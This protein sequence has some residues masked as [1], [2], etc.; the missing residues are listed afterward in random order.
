MVEIP[1]AEGSPS[2]DLQVESVGDEVLI[3]DPELDAVK[4]EDS[5]FD[6]NLAE[7]MSDKEL[8]RTASDL[9]GFS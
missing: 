8:S 9:I 3:G 5:N 2:D 4:E 6:N 7:D 1:F